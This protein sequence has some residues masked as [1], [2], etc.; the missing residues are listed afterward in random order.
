MALVSA[1]M[2]LCNVSMA[3]KEI[4]L[5]LVQEVLEMKA[6]QSFIENSYWRTFPTF[7]PGSHI[8]DEV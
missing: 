8:R 5:W 6:K 2:F 7:E 3:G 1:A 4:P